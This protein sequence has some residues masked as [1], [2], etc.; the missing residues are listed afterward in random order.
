MSRE[1][2]AAFLK[3]LGEDPAMQELLVQFAAQNGFEFTVE[4]LS[5]AD[6][7]RIAAGLMPTRRD[8][9]HLV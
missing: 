6:L 8:H 3:R 2:V 1:A 5:E 9:D 7:D 4:E